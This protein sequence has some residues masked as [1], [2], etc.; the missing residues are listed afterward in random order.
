MTRATTT[1]ASRVIDAASKLVRRGADAVS[2]RRRGPHVPPSA[3][4]TDRG[5]HP[6]LDPR[7]AAPVRDRGAEG[8]A[9]LD[10][11]SPLRGTSEPPLPEF[12][13]PPP[14]LKDAAAQRHLER[15]G[16]AI[17]PVVPS[18]V[19]AAAQELYARLGPAPD[20][21]Q[22]ALNWT[23]HSQSTEHKRAV[24]EEMLSLF[25][26]ILDSIL[27]D[28]EV[29]LTT[30]ITKWPGPNSGFAPHQDPSLVDEREFRGV[31]IWIPLVDTGTVEGRDNGALHFVPG[32]HEFSKTLR[33]SDVDQ[34]PLAGHE[35]DI[36][37]RH[38]VSAPTTAGDVLVFDNRVIHYSMPNETDEPR[39]VM[40][41][42]VRPAASSCVLLR[43]DGAG[44]VDIY[45]VDDDFYIDVL[46][47]QQH[48][49]EPPH[50]PLAKVR[51]VTPSWTR[52]QFAALC[53]R[54]PRPDGVVRSPGRT[55]TWQ[56][57]GV[58]CALCG[59]TEGLGD[60]DR[61]ARNNAQLICMS[62]NAGLERQSSA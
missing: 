49:W 3:A 18:D 9:A 17:L 1:P 15:F 28:H 24:K 40:S 10:E 38:G 35:H 8:T 47:A 4:Q 22:I 14:T 13:D 54:S 45:E 52:E 59:S 33:V 46:P 48:L 36:V 16:F 11:P 53:D 58:F 39:V 19:I 57:P 61:A 12:V 50:Q 25:S 21:P 27:D 26:P 30:F 56:D 55:A 62:C 42:G 29:Y 20:D 32:S 2:S 31:T 51:M 5:G 34:S 37:E 7:V 6:P 41:F 60:T 44:G 23:F 43:Q